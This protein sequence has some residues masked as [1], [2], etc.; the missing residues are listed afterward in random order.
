MT[1]RNKILNASKWSSLS[2]LSVKLIT[3]L[4]FIV[5]ARIL[6][7]EDFGVTAG[8]AIIISFCQIFWDAG[9]SKALIQRQDKTSEIANIVFWTNLVAATLIYFLLIIFSERIAALF[10]DGRLALVI[11][12]QGIQV[13]LSSLYSVHTAI[14]QKKLNFKTLFY[15]RFSTSVIPGLISLPLAMI[16]FSYWSLVIG[17]IF[18]ALS[19]LIAHWISNPWRPQ[20][21]YDF[22]LAIRL[23][24]Y[25]AWV[26]AESLLTWVVIWLD[27]LVVGSFLGV[28][29]LGLYRTGNQFLNMVFGL[30]FA[31]LLPVLFSSFSRMQ[32]DTERLREILLKSSTIFSFI[33]LPASFGIFLLQNELAALIFGSKWI[34]IEPVIGLLALT[35]GLSWIVGANSQ[36][37]L[38]IGRPDI[39]TK[40]IFVSLM[41]YIPAF[42]ISIHFGLLSFLFARFGVAVLAIPIHLYCAQKYIGLR[43]AEFLDNIKWFVFSSA[44]MVLAVYQIKVNLFLE[45][46]PILRL[47][48]LVLSGVIIYAVFIL[49]NKIFLKFLLG[50]FS[51]EIKTN[52]S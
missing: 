37:Y 24:N 41:F 39:S 16:G 31:P 46:N 43:I 19:Q 18:G 30:F 8:A 5:L 48:I 27:A 3:P 29:Q 34:G 50:L 2:E 6:T 23:F 4:L 12:V 38:A 20:L 35:H 22:S 1:L 9:L 17:S 7:P 32:H 52:E 45:I 42:L 14:L 40:I 36:A 51:K 33:A 10:Q 28:Q 21:T 25:G 13:V 15:I 47:I 11:R 49:R 44:F 26:S